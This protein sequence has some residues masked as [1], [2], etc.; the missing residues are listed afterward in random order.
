MDAFL[1]IGLFAALAM[2]V[3]VAQRA[4]PL[5]PAAP[6]GLFSPAKETPR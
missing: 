5:N 1:T 6:R 4:P 3:M 2:L